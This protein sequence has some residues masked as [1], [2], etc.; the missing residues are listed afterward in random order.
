MCEGGN[1]GKMGGIYVFWNCFFC[2]ILFGRCFVA[3]AWMN[4]GVLVFLRRSG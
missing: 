4:I 3:G 1:T 2:G